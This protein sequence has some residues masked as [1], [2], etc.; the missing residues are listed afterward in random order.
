[1]IEKQ[2]QFEDLLNRIKN[3]SITSCIQSL[4]ILPQEVT[5]KL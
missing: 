4:Q 5:L 2:Q 1:M 3:C